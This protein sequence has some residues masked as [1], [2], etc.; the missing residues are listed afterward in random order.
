MEFG[1][2]KDEIRKQIDVGIGFDGIR[3]NL[4]EWEEDKEWN[5]KRKVEKQKDI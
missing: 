5:A 4:K 3:E 2:L 1:G